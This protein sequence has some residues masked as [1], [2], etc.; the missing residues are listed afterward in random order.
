[1]WIMDIEPWCELRWKD[2]DSFVVETMR[3]GRHCAVIAWPRLTRKACSVAFFIKILAALINGATLW[4]I[5]GLIVSEAWQRLKDLVESDAAV[6]CSVA[7]FRLAVN[8]SKCAAFIRSAPGRCRSE[9]V[10][11]KGGGEGFRIFSVDFASGG[12]T[13]AINAL[14][15]SPK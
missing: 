14:V 13:F 5:E 1:M 11:P 10:G 4:V 8:I 7:T 3:K 9:V 6:K 15:L 2:C 12:F